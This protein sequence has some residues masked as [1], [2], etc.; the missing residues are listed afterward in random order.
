VRVPGRERIEPFPTCLNPMTGE[1]NTSRS[2]TKTIYIKLSDTGFTGPATADGYLVFNTSIQGNV[3]NLGTRANNRIVFE[4]YV[5][6]NNG[7]NSTPAT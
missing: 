2:S 4:S 1:T 7:Q 3:A 6:P 5:E